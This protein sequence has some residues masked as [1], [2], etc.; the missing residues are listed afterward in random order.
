MPLRSTCWRAS[1]W[2]FDCNTKCSA[3]SNRSLHTTHHSVMANRNSLSEYLL[4]DLKDCTRY[5]PTMHDREFGWQETERL[6]EAH[7]CVSAGEIIKGMHTHTLMTGGKFLFNDEPIPAHVV[8]PGAFSE[9][10]KS[11]RDAAPRVLGRP[12]TYEDMLWLMLTSVS[13]NQDACLTEAI[14]K[15]YHRFY[16]ELD[17]WFAKKHETAKEWNDFV[18]SVCKVVGQAVMLCYPESVTTRD[19]ADHFQFA[20]L[21]T[22][23]LPRQE[24]FG[25][26]DGAQAWDSH[27]MAGR[28]C[29]P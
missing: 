26:G 28:D 29:R 22:Q 1:V 21:C 16:L 6:R 23:G 4:Y 10:H 7:P 3:R 13:W 18:R 19:P 15:P 2:F 24:T 14:S 25:H 11:L 17:V 27:G 20:I 12:E 9:L 8:F 5:P